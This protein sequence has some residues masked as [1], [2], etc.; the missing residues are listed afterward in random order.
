MSLTVDNVY[1]FWDFY[2]LFLGLFGV[3]WNVCAEQYARGVERFEE[4]SQGVV[5]EVHFVDINSDILIEIRS[6]FSHMFKVLASHE[7]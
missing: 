5:Q 4:D 1:D 7:D 2:L 3:P 6:V